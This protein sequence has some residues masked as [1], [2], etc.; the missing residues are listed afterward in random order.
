MTNPRVLLRDEAAVMTTL[1]ET[2]HLPTGDPTVI[3]GA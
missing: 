1:V 2:R 3:T